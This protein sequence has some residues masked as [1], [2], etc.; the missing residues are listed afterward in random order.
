LLYV[1]DSR[2]KASPE[3]LLANIR[4]AATDDLLD[5]VTVFREAMEPEAVAVIEAELARRGLGPDEI[6]THRHALQHRVLRDERGLVACCR[7]CPRAAT[8][9][10]RD[11]HRWLGLVPLFKRRFYYC[12]AC[13][14][15]RGRGSS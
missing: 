14:E 15:R 8:Q 12:D 10:A 4:T 5:R 1:K 9:T 11:W 2:V 3:R 13:W 7:R 6:H